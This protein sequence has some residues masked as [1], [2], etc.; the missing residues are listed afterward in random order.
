MVCDPGVTE[1]EGMLTVA[2]NRG[3]VSV[4]VRNPQLRMTDE[5]PRKHSQCSPLLQALSYSIC[6][7]ISCQAVLLS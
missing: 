5:L 6:R 1:L 3:F 7:S 2:V 4:G